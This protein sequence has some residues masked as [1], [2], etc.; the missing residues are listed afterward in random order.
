[1]VPN[2]SEPG[3]QPKSRRTLA[4]HRRADALRKRALSPIRIT[5]MVLMLPATTAAIAISVYLRTSEFESHDALLHLIAMSGCKFAEALVPGPYLDGQPG[6]HARNDVDGNGVACE[7][8]VPRLGAPS[9]SAEAG[10][11]NETSQEVGGSQPRKLGT[12]KFLRP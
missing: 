12:A 1:M 3:L 2:D 11:S 10:P 5:F 6:Y 4:R 8:T 9:Q 7:A